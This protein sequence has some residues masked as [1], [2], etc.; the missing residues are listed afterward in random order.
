[1]ATEVPPLPHLQMVDRGISQDYKPRRAA[2]RRST[3]PGETARH[4]A[5]RCASSIQAFVPLGQNLQLQREAQKLD[6]LVPAG[7][8]IEFQSAQGF[9][10]A[11]KSLDLPSE[12]IELLNF[13]E[14][15]GV[16][17]ATCFVPEGKLAVLVKKVRDYIQ[18]NTPTGKPKNNDLVASIQS[19]GMATIEA[20]WT[21]EVP[22]PDDNEVHWWEVWLRRDKDMQAE[23]CL[24]RFAAT[25]EILNL[26]LAES[27]MAFPDRVVVN[28][29]ATR[30]QL[31][32]AAELLNLIAEIRRADLPPALPHEPT[33][34]QQDEFV[35]DL[36]ARLQPLGKDAVAVAILDTGIN[37]TH[38]LIHVALADEDL[39]AVDPAGAHTTI[40]ATVPKWPASRC[41]VTCEARRGSTRS[42]CRT[43]WSP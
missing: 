16:Q 34:K 6:Q 8:V 35:E 2:A 12:G 23:V 4:T 18:A 7:I 40:T 30:E 39:H 26:T 9:D 25:A 43:D 11:F 36:V 5:A 33:L 42:R 41:T 10:L 28:I 31:A 1:M 29:E 3:S 17:Y 13:K 21:D 14:V 24:Q 22:L 19:I 27:W 20:F 37:H 38:P 32:R 15:D